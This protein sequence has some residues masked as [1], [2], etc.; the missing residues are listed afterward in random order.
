MFLWGL[1]CRFFDTRPALTASDV[2]ISNVRRQI[3]CV[4][5][6]TLFNTRS[7]TQD[8]WPL[9]VVKPKTCTNRSAWPTLESWRTNRYHRSRCW[10]W[11]RAK[12]ENSRIWSNVMETWWTMEQCS[13]ANRSQR[14]PASCSPACCKKRSNAIH[15]NWQMQIYKWSNANA[16]HK[17]QGRK[18]R[19]LMS[20]GRV[21]SSSW[22]LYSF[23]KSRVCRILKYFRW[24]SDLL[25]LAVPLKALNSLANL[26]YTNNF[27]I[28][29]V[30]NVYEG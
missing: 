16:I 10:Q 4:K 20:G 1:Q 12:E 23:A 8:F 26:G 24:K 29:N 17:T 30:I 25:V 15:T 13:W 28:K 7:S 19:H 18:W 6:Q 22:K 27:S 21:P 9:L 14:M 2:H 3:R 5:V 11:H